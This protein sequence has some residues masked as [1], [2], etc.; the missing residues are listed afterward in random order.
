MNIQALLHIPDSH[1]CYPI[2]INEIVLRLRTDRNDEFDKIEVVYESKYVIYDKQKIEPLEL[3]YTD[4][5]YS[6]YE[7]KL[8]LKDVRIGY[9]F[10]ITQKGE[11][12]YFSE[13]GITKEY[14]FR[15]AYYNSFQMAYI[16][17]CDV[18]EIVPWMQQAVFYQIFPDRFYQGNHEKDCSYITMRW[19]EIPKA[20]GFAGGDIKGITKKVD[21]LKGIG[22]NAIYLT[23][24]FTSISNHKYDISN[25]K[26][27]DPQFGTKEELRELIE[28]LHKNGMRIVLDAV[29]NH[30]SM[31]LEEFQDVVK[32]GKNSKY[33]D[34]FIIHGD[35]VDQEN[36]NYEVFAFCEY[37]PK[38]NT[39][40]PE[41]QK[42]LI[43]IATYW[44]REFDIDGWRLDVSD[45]VSHVFWRKFRE[46]VKA[47]KSDCV[48]IGENWH[49]ANVYLHGDQYDSIMNYAFT[50]ACLDYYAFESKN[51]NQFEEKLS[52]LVMRNTSTVN[53]MMLNLLDSHDVDRFYTQVKKNKD[54]MLSALA[55]TFMYV[56]VPCIYYGTEL[57][58]EG[59][60][61]PDNR[62]CFDW[63]E[64]NWDK[65]YQKCLT[66][67]IALRK[68]E[69]V[70]KGDISFTSKNDL[71]YL[72]RKYKDITMILITNES[73]ED[74]PV[75]IA[76]EVLIS[77]QYKENS[78]LN[79]GFVVIERKGD[80]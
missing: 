19:G 78:L 74:R 60:Y 26:E 73:G 25:Y 9:V 11:R 17:K 34:W 59:G 8:K 22:V 7:V 6:Y 79:H 69:T 45:E 36:L 24:I 35:K 12:F 44:I 5:L 75:D 18:H 28:K 47:E 48:I 49:D 67:I 63:D 31:L 72:K 61:D 55:T 53:S 37:M 54:K 29:F 23:P 10:L 21:Y 66:K 62:R 65:E 20:K 33:F 42:Y 68:M 38:F 1:Y 71:F 64:N 40:N 76:G 27:I 32:K 30:S 77:N 3:K 56:G 52:K 50:K 43:D 41:V 46:A 80:L 13:D 16:N 39:S 70:Q 51:A 4:D 14:N 15:L 2:S 58:M 57:A